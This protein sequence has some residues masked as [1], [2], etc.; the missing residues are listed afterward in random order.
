MTA[1]ANSASP[2]SVTVGP[3]IH[4]PSL[5]PTPQGQARSSS[6]LTGIRT[7]AQYLQC[8]G[9]LPPRAPGVGVARLSRD[10]RSHVA[11]PQ[12]QLAPESGGCGCQPLL[13]P[14]ESKKPWSPQHARACWHLALALGA[15]REAA[16]GRGLKPP[17][18]R[19][20][21]CQGGGGYCEDVKG[22][23]SDVHTGCHTGRPHIP[24]RRHSSQPELVR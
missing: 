12:G 8:G 4:V 16:P 19:D 23:V 10:T 14:S 1:G 22:V 24:D 15:G 20:C 3:A 21:T 17:S 9:A 7:R 18:S 6:W 13:P 5:P 11:L 2:V